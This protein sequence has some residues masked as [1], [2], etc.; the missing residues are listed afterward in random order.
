MNEESPYNVY[1]PGGQPDATIVINTLTGGLAEIRRSEAEALQTGKAL[2]GDTLPG[3]ATALEAIG[4]LTNS[5]EGQRATATAAFL[6]EQLNTRDL[7]VVIPL[8][9]RCNL[10][11]TYCYQVLHGDFQGPGAQE[12]ASW[13]D[14]SITALASFV[15]HQLERDQYEGLR[16]RWYGGEPLLKLDLIN[17]IGTAAQDVCKALGTRL[18][19]MVVTNGTCLSERAIATLRKYN[20]D[21]LEISIDGPLELHDLLRQSRSGKSTYDQI[22]HAIVRASD[23]F[24]TIVFRVNVHSRNVEHIEPW[25]D[26]IAPQIKR[27]NIFLKFKLVEG[28]KTNTLDYPTFSAISLRYALAARHLG[29]KLLQTRL[30]TETCPAIR[31]NYYIVQSDLRVYKCPQ[32]LGSE[33]NVGEIAAD[34][35]C[36]TNWRFPIWTAYDTTNNDDCKACKQMPHCNGGCPYNEIMNKINAASL[37]IYSRKERCC[38]ERYVPEHLL[39]RLL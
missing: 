18:S 1:F 34:G 12:I 10:K 30:S 2:P 38:R 4:A 35:Q 11:C 32:N 29:L 27:P 37:E 31:K 13:T 20:V 21:R 24:E 8:T 39:L 16:L 36:E 7:N 9:S 6:D 22:L 5:P 19:G 15:R 26:D 23:A 14:E 28:D 17:K 25:L 3:T 33:D